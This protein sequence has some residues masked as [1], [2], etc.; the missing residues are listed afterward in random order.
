L[1]DVPDQLVPF[2]TGFQ[3]QGGRKGGALRHGQQPAFFGQQG[4]RFFE[5]RSAGKG[6]VR[7]RRIVRSPGPLSGLLDQIRQIVEQLV[8]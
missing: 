7:A 4:D 6:L 5:G 3:R 8:R 2:V 1:Q